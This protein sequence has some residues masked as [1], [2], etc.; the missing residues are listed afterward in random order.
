MANLDRLILERGVDRLLAPF[1]G[2]GPGMTIGL[3]QDGAL[4]LHRS[5][6]MASVEHRVPIGP[7]TRFRIASVSKQFTCAAILLLAHDGRLSLDDDVR[8]HIP[9]LSDTGHRVT[10]AHLMHNTSGIRDMLEIMRQGGADLGMPVGADALLWAVAR[11]RTLNFEPGTRFLYSNSNFMLLGR[12]A[13]RVTGEPLEDMLERRIFAPLGMTS[14]LMTPDV[15]V[16]VPNLA[17]GYFPNDG[18]G[19]R[20]A[21]HAFALHGEGGLVSSVE[22][23]ALWDRNLDTGLVGGDWL[24]AALSAQAAF[25]NG[26]TNRYARGQAVRPYRG[27]DTVSHGGLWPGYRTEF[28]RVPAHAT[29]VI[30][31]ANTGR[32]DPNLVAHQVL[33]LVLARTL[34][35][36]P[37]PPAP[38]ML[39]R[40]V[41]RWLD[42]A[43]TATLDVGRTP[44]G[45]LS[46]MQNGLLVTAE[47]DGEGWMAAPRAS[48][49]F[50]VRS[51]GPDALEVEQDAG[52]VAAWHRVHEGAVLPNGLEGR[53]RSDEI[54]ATWTVR[55][56]GGRATVRAL[57]PVATGA[58]WDV[59]PIEGDV[60][61]IHV[62][63][64]LF[65]AWLDVRVL[66]NE[67]GHVAGLEVNGGRV[68]RVRYER[69]ATRFLI[70]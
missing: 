22:D 37:P 6:G 50:R 21:P 10:I 39:E 42:D 45:G 41:G 47:P 17:T 13:E 26:T 33:D 65:Q 56:D 54:D 64:T 32:A 15:Q 12:I 44:T 14:T 23:L 53:Y 46:L 59:E 31:I 35:P 34:H 52:R 9:E 28:L 3:V 19:W 49:V 4:I 70:A 66:W 24:A 51:A 5:A 25:S 62:P 16:A 30:V 40:L 63:G 57:G 60:L 61:R 20:R 27:A 8:T 67:V 48:S 55:V 1:A 18:G 7:A 68:R 11:Q 36:V 29:S 38:D 2:D 43:T 69:V 58:A